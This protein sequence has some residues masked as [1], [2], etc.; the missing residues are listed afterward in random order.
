VIEP[1]DRKARDVQARSRRR[2]SAA[3]KSGL[4]LTGLGTVVLGAGYIAGVNAPAVARSNTTQNSTPQAVA[5]TES[6]PPAAEENGLRSP[7][8]AGGANA[9]LFMGYDEDGNAVFLQNDGTVV[10]GDDGFNS[11]SQ[12]SQ[13]FK[14]QPNP[15]S[16]GLTQQQPNFRRPLTRSRGS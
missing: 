8:T 11:G 12:P 13:Q 9:A 6:N 3:W 7:N 1:N 14:A 10:R 16:R 2:K 4:V 5:Q 15:Q